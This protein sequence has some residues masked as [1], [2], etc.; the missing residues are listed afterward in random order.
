MKLANEIGKK[1]MYRY[2]H[3]TVP[4]ILKQVIFYLH[5]HK[6]LPI[7]NLPSTYTRTY[8]VHTCV[9]QSDVSQRNDIMRLVR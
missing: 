1:L 2:V 4:F 7:I 5:A 6:L 9:P 3:R 8:T